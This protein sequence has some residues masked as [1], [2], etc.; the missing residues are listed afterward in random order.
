MAGSATLTNGPYAPY[1][2]S[3]A[4]GC[5]GRF[6][7]RLC[8]GHLFYCPC[9][10]LPACR[11]PV[12]CCGSLVCA[13]GHR[14]ASLWCGRV[15]ASR[16]QSKPLSNWSS[17]GCDPWR[18]GAHKGE[19]VGEWALQ[20]GVELLA[21]RILEAACLGAAGTRYDS[22]PGPPPTSLFRLC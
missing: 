6:A 4:N 9:R 5:R 16:L 19:R 2:F 13:S 15:G 18:P 11:S 22:P 21:D 20:C 10:D 3:Y 7:Y 1:F 8:H 12:T 14:S 17:Q